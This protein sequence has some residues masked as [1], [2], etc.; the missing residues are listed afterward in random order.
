MLTVQEYGTVELD[1]SNVELAGL[2]RHV[3]GTDGDER[4]LLESLTPTGRGQVHRLK[5]GSYV[6]RLALPG[7]RILEFTSRFDLEELL[8]LL[9]LSGRLPV[10]PNDLLVEV[11]ES[12]Q[13]VELIA[14]AFVR[15]VRRLVGQGLAKGY[16]ERRFLHPPYPGRLDPNHHLARLAG[17]PDRLVTV[18]K[19]LSVDVPVNQAVGCALDVLR[20]A[21]VLDASWD[22]PLE[23]LAASFRYVSRPPMDAGELARIPLSRLTLRYRP[24][25]ALASL[26]LDLHAVG[27]EAGVK[28]GSSLLFHM[29]SIWEDFVEAWVR[30]QTT[31]DD[32]QVQAQHTFPVTHDG[33]IKGRA[34]VVQR[35]NGRL[36]GLFDAKYKLL[37]RSPRAGDVSQMIAYMECLG[38]DHATL[39]YPGAAAPRTIGVGRRR[40]T[41]IGVDPTP[42]GVEATRLPLVPS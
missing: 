29:P 7:G 34:D 25:L 38:L 13:P 10:Q 8:W 35:R 18:A 22:G 24:A 23:R 42:A 9:C 2:L 17:R 19:R 31:D 37:H 41:S 30:H 32:T 1:L 21:E 36:V 6:G 16:Q 3:R 26:I 40:I 39:V 15:E 33:D 12:A 4:R 11:G 14:R 27:P 28:P 20:R 5:A